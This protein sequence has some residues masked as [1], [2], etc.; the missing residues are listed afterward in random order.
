MRGWS[1]VA[2]QTKVFEAEI[3]VTQSAPASSITFEVPQTGRHLRIV[4]QVRGTDAAVQEVIMRFNGDTGNNYDVAILS[5]TGSAVSS[6]ATN[7]SSIRIGAAPATGATA[8]YAAG[9]F[10]WVP[11]Y[12]GTVFH[13][14]VP[15]ECARVDSPIIDVV[16]GL[17]HPSTPVPIRSI[18][19]ALAAGNFAAGSMFGVYV[20][21]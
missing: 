11:N 13:K 15:S 19:L 21:L 1:V 2:P 17:W 12:T 5:G 8:G 16:Q 10:A 20:E 9:G 14:A 6:T 3:G 4:Y 7:R 18:T